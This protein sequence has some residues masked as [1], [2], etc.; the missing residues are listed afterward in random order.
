[1]DLSRGF[2]KKS[3][4]FEH[5]QLLIFDINKENATIDTYKN[6]IEFCI[7]LRAKVQSDILVAS[8]VHNDICLLK[9]QEIIWA[10]NSPFR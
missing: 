2:G 5:A 4:E 3:G 9:E 8:E 7:Y 10:Q 1:M 6:V